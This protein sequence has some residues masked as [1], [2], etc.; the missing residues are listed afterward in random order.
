ML[1]S[2]LLQPDSLGLSFLARETGQE[3]LSQLPHMAVRG[4]SERTHRKGSRTMSMRFMNAQ[5][6][7]DKKGRGGLHLPR[8]MSHKIPLG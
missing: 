2:A 7:N 8:G 4:T 3:C 1:E 5:C 6:G